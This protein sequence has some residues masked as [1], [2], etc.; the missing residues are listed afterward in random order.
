MK[1]LTVILGKTFSGKPTLLK[2]ITENT[3]YQRVLTHT[4]RPPRIGEK[5]GRDYYFETQIKSNAIALRQY[6]VIDN[7]IWSYWSTKE[8][9]ATLDY[10]LMIIDHQGF[11][12]LIAALPDF[13]IQ[14]IYLNVNSDTILKRIV[15]H[16]SNR[17]QENKRESI[18]RLV[19]DT[20]NNFKDI[21]ETSHIITANTN[22]KAKQLLL[23]RLG[24]LPLT[25]VRGL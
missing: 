20:L 9:L 5:N 3:A 10:P 25:K 17:T 21:T 23:L 16:K 8:D 24:Q 12:D 19:D 15:N 18:R 1:N 22:V 14:G 4:T 7:Q 6:H 2:D 11:K 13:D